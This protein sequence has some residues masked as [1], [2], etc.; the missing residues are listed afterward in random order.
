[1]VLA[2]VMRTQDKSFAGNIQFGDKSLKVGLR[3][4]AENPLTEEKKHTASEYLTYVALD[5]NNRP[6]VLPPLILEKNQDIHRNKEAQERRQ[7]RL[8]ESKKEKQ[9]R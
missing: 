8:A 6:I 9:S 2:Q 1:M 3:V 4:E 7:M 5:R